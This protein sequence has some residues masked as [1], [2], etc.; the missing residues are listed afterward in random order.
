[1]ATI[2]EPKGKARE[3]SPLALNPYLGCNHAC[4]YCYVPGIRRCSPEQNLNIIEKHNFI[5]DLKKDARNLKDRNQQVL[6]SFMSDP[7]NSL[8]PEKKLTRKS[9]KILLDNR[10]PCAILTKAGTKALGDMD[11]F[12]LF[13]KSIQVGATLTLENDKDSFFWESGAALPSDRIEMLKQLKE[14]GIKTW[15]SFEPVIDPVQSVNLIKKV[16]DYVDIFKIGKLNNIYSEIQNKINWQEYLKTIV[17]IL[18]SYNKAFYVKYDLR[19][20]CPEV[21]LFGNEV[22]QDEHNSLPFNKRH[23][24]LF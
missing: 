8:E 6:L 22:L 23:E 16:I 19:R 3:Y 15:A 2:Y 12:K 9:L 24:T 4:K 14:N 5:D 18:R 10:I 20:I 13:G 7:Y 1:M 11:I 21:K 17:S